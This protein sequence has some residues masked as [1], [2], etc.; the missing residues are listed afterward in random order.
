M[1]AG[2]GMALNGWLPD[3]PIDLTTWGLVLMWTALTVF[4]GFQLTA[5]IREFTR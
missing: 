4:N 3:G 1:R 5:H 2:I